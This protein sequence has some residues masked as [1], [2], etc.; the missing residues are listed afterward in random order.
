MNLQK[1][2]Y[3]YDVA[4]VV[5]RPLSLTAWPGDEATVILAQ[6]YVK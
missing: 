5:L 2:V 6:D 1:L 3:A 4:T